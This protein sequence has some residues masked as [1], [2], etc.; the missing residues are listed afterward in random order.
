M[1]APAV[2][3]AA[4]AVAAPAAAQDS[5]L[6]SPRAGFPR[7]GVQVGGSLGM[8]V[9]LGPKAE[10]PRVGLQGGVFGEASVL[11]QSAVGGVGGLELGFRTVPGAGVRGEFLGRLGGGALVNLDGVG[12]VNVLVARLEGGLAFRRRDGVAGVVGA[13]V[14]APGLRVREIHTLRPLGDEVRWFADVGAEVGLLPSGLIRPWMI[15]PTRYASGG[16]DG[17]TGLE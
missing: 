10:A 4:L 2:L 1:G 14:R 13:A 17:G 16:G 7:P 11:L 9:R 5:P 15:R 8:S 3:L 6:P 12:H